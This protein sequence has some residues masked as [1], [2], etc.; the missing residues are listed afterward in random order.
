MIKSKVG[1]ILKGCCTA[2]VLSIICIQH[3]S[4][5]LIFTAPPREDTEHGNQIY[6]P[7]ADKLSAIL[8]EKVV[9]EHPAG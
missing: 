4:A 5:E 6:G 7:I 8:G 2:L 1:L 3:A 9:Y